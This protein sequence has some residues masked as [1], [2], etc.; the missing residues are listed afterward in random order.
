MVPAPA[1]ADALPVS[2]RRKEKRFII[3]VPGRYALASRWTS[4]GERRQFLCRAV[5]ISASAIALA[6][7][8]SGPLQERVLA[9]MD[10]LGKMQGRIIRSLSRGFVMSIDTSEEDRAK[11]IKRV[12]WL[13]KHKALEVDDRRRHSRFVPRSP[14]SRLILADGTV[15][16]CFVVDLS[17]SGAAVSAEIDPEIGTV[18]AVGSVVG[19]VVRRF[20]GGFALEFASVQPRDSVEDMVIAGD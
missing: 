5:N 7:P 14:H 16:S 13:D 18:L 9:E 3:S 20:A 12:E 2:D 11:L 1:T 4:H 8:V 17:E 15:M 6:A 19:R 10:S